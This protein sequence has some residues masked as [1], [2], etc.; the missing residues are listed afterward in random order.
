MKILFIIDFKE[1]LRDSITRIIKMVCLGV[2]QKKVQMTSPR[3][4]L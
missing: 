2:C 3:P 4:G 1:D